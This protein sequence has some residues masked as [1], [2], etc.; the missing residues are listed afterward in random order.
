MG[1]IPGDAWSEET[2]VAV[3]ALYELEDELADAQEMH[4]PDADGP[5]T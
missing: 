4:K 2:S 1:S 5:Q 3:A